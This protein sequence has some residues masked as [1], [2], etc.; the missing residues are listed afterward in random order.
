M[1]EI[2]ERIISLMKLIAVISFPHPLIS[3]KLLCRWGFGIFARIEKYCGIKLTPVR[4]FAR[5]NKFEK[6]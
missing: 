6:L 1:F 3:A 4:I 5:A 2:D